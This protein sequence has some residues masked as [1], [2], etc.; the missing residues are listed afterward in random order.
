MVLTRVLLS[1]EPAAEPGLRNPLQRGLEASVF[2]VLGKWPF[3]KQRTMS[4]LKDCEGLPE[5]I[6]SSACCLVLPAEFHR[7][8]GFVMS[9]H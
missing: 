7:Q 2:D 9:L 1:G 5:R 4:I 8:D 3:R 6:E